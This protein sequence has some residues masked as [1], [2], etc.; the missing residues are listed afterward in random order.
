MFG[1]IFTM[2]LLVMPWFFN[3]LT[4]AAQAIRDMAE[5]RREI[6]PLPMARADEVG[7]LVSGFNVLVERLRTEEA[8]RAASEER[9][10]YL[11]HHDALTGLWNRAMLEERLEFALGCAERDGTQIALLFCDLDDFK[12]INDRYGHDAG[13]AVLRDV[14]ARLGDGRRRADT[15]ARLGGDEFVILLTGLQDAH[16]AAGIVARQVLASVTQPY[17]VEG[18]SATVGMSIGIA[19]HAGPAVAPSYLIAQADVAMYEV[20]RTGKQDFFFMQDVFDGSAK[21]SA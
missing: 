15:V 1:F 12:A 2:M 13:D 21:R 14:A 8:A 6:E 19:V 17:V 10:K 20:K 4:R 9:L 11:A 7:Q 16:E 18:E 3:P 5:G